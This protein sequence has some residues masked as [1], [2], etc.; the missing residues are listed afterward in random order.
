MTATTRIDP[1]DWMGWPETAAVLSALGAG[2]APVRFVGGCVRDALIGVTPEDVDI[3]TPEPPET[4]MARLA[5]AAIRALPIGIEHGTITGVIGER[6]FEI[7]TLRRDV[8]HF[9]RHAR[10]AF[11]DDWQADAERRDFTINAL[12]AEPDGTIHDLTGGLDD[13]KAGRV[14]FIGEAA[15]RIAEDYLRVLR[16]FRFHARFARGA[17]DEA[18]IAACAEAAGALE[19]LS[20]ERVRGELFRLLALPDPLAG[21]GPMRDCGVLAA[22]LPEAG[23]LGRIEALL[24]LPEESDSLVRLAALLADNNVERNMERARSAAKRL[25]LSNAGAARLCRLLAGEPRLAA[26]MDDGAILRGLYRTDPETMRDRALLAWAASPREAGFAGLPERIASLPVPA[27]PLQGADL[28][29]AGMSP[30]PAVG[31]VLARLES[32][33]LEDDCR[34]DRAALLA[35]LT[36]M[37]GGNGTG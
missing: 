17:P 37:T 21:L 32:L 16:F 14:R 29:A 33:W 6:R 35:H 5:A 8:E 25:R 26:D 34:P 18:A 3:A 13:L 30:G 7:T 27:F 2:G 12:F 11:V 23:G 31:R 1:P 22:V 9:G 10:V 24:A 20:A 19:R 4:V 15:T 28:L 36:E